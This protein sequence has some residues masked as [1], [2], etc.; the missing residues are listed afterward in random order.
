MSDRLQSHSLTCH[1]SC[2]ITNLPI[3]SAAVL[4][5]NVS[6]R[7]QFN[8]LNCHISSSPTNLLVTS[9]AILLTYL[10]HKLQSHSLTCLIRCSFTSLPVSFA[11][12]A[13][14]TCHIGCSLTTYKSHPSDSFIL[15]LLNTSLVSKT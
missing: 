4:L 13:L 12:V 7:L 3:N 5:T 6:Y 9:A 11:V 2:S 15:Q 8:Q 14:L 1:I 10:S